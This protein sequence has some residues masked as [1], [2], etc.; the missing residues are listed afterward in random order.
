MLKLR[1][2]WSSGFAVLQAVASGVAVSFGML[3]LPALGAVT[4]WERPRFRWIFSSRAAILLLPIPAALLLPT[5]PFPR[6]FIVLWPFFAL[7]AGA[8]LRD[9]TAIN[10]RLDHRWNERIWLGA[11]LAIVLGFAWFAE[12]PQLKLA[13][14]RRNG[15]A[16]QDDFFYS[17]YL[18]PEHRPSE[19][20]AALGKRFPNGVANCY[21][22]FGADPWALMFY[23]LLEGIPIRNFQFDGPR[24]PV[25][26]LAPET[27]VVLRADES[28]VGLEK[29]FGRKLKKCYENGNHHVYLAE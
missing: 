1:E 4:A 16:A 15:G 24:G 12:R 13:F 21:V 5:A 14:S 11:L 19:T 22:S 18:R 3:L 17:Y 9:L 26:A 6:V 27:P 10:C 7:L 25:A 20:A 29:R 8:G 2:G 23:S 28:P